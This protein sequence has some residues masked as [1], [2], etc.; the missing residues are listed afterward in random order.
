MTFRASMIED[1]D[2]FFEERIITLAF[3]Q[4]IAMALGLAPFDKSKLDLL[5]RTK[6]ALIKKFNSPNLLCMQLITLLKSSN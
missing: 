3:W 1:E 6:I 2:I 5:K 4:A